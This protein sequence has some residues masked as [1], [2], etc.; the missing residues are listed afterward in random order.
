MLA[1]RYQLTAQERAKMAI[2][3]GLR[4]IA[5][6]QPNSVLW[7][8]VIRGLCVRR[9]HSETTTWSIVY[10][11]KENHQRWQKLGRFPVFTPKIARQEASKILLAVA[12]GRDPAEERYALR[13]SMTISQLC[14]LYTA[15]TESGKMNGKK[16]STILSDR[17]RIKIHIKPKLG[18]HKVVSLRQE[19][20]EE[21]MNKLPLGSA[22]RIIGL[23]GTMFTFAI[24]RKIVKIN[25]VAGIETPSDNK[26]TR[27]LSD[28]EY[29]Q[30]QKAIAHMANK[31]AASVITLIAISGWRSGEVMNLRWSELDS[32]RHVAMLEDTKTGKSARALSRAAID[33]I[34]KQHTN[35]IYVFE[36]ENG[37]PIPALRFHWLKLQMPSDITPHTLRHSFASLAADL[38][39]ADHTIAGLL[40][41]AR[42]SITSRYM[43]LADKAL[44]EAADLVA[45]ETLRLMRG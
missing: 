28:A 35:G 23:F 38:G 9:Q 45:S 4:D 16:T 11:T 18:K 30:L 6:M 7:D 41:H 29:A 20:V 40:G 2:K 24:K 32:E 12:Q 19:Q 39:L 34:R 27:R 31:T 5:A 10:R 22:K 1:I 13:N 36:S 37:H 14:D 21:F 26:K 42:Q 43:H 25:P 15:D 17:S 44:I 33:L 3:I 8:S